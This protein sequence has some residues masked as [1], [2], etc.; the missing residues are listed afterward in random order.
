MTYGFKLAHNVTELRVVGM[1]KEI[2]EDY[3]RRVRVRYPFVQ[4]HNQGPCLTLVASETTWT[5][6]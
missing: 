3:N 2:E 5:I 4:T 1:L 6:A